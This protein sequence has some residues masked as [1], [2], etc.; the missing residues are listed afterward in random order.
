MLK[1]VRHR[2]LELIMNLLSR[3]LEVKSRPSVVKRLY[4]VVM[5]SAG[6]RNEAFAGPLD[7]AKGKN[8]AK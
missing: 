5:V 7:A 1:V 6:A 8:N 4:K 2:R 3:L